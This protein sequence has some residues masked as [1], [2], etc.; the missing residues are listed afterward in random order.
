YSP[1][2]PIITGPAQL[3]FR[4]S[5]DF[6]PNFD[7]AVLEIAVGTQPFVDIL[8][9]GGSFAANGYNALLIPGSTALGGRPGWSG[10]SGGWV[11]TEVN[12]PSSAAP[13]PIQLRWRLASDSSRGGNGWFIDD[14][15]VS[16]YPCA[17]PVTNPVI[18]R[19]RFVENRY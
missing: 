10:N 3:T 2:L 15:A 9:A 17:P 5:F 11:V 16:Q 8:Q 6:E 14:V 7:G 18:L 4:H 1:V 13:Q 12:L 19:P